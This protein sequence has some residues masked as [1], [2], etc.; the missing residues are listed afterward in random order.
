MPKINWGWGIV[1]FLFIFVGTVGYRIYI[2]SQQKINLVTP[3]YYPKGIAYEEEITKKSNYIHLDGKLEIIQKKD[4]IYV[5]IPG[6]SQSAP[7][8][9]SLLVYHPA[10]FEDDSAF[11]FSFQDSNRVFSFAKDFLKRGYYEVVVDWQEDSVGFVATES[12]FVNK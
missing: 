6:R 8:S 5:V 10:D 9:G 7:M 3:D 2:A 1:I 12:M 4:S 11:Q